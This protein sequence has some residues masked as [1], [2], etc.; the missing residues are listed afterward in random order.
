[1]RAA[2]WV[3]A[4]TS[5]SRTR[6]AHV[7]RRRGSRAVRSAYP[8]VVLRST[9]AESHTRVANGV[10]LHLIDGHLG[11]VAVD[12]LDK[13]AALARRDLDICDLAKSLEERSQL[14]FSHIS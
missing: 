8:G 13:A 4:R 2:I 10:A 7:V 1:M 12:K 9:P 11:G 3:R 6:H 5:V 14:V